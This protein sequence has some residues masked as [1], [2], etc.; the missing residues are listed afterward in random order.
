[1]LIGILVPA[2]NDR[3]FENHS[4]WKVREMQISVG[5]TAKILYAPSIC[6]NLLAVEEDVQPQA[7]TEGRIFIFVSSRAFET[8]VVVTLYVN[9]HLSPSCWTFANYFTDSCARQSQISPSISYRLPAV[10]SFSA[11]PRVLLRQ[12]A[13]SQSQTPQSWIRTS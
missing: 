9:V 13:Q 10:Y 2:K 6:L 5:F 7:R 3:T 8:F 12:E 4:K 1:L 11:A